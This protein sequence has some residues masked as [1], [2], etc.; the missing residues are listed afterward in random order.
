MLTKV[1]DVDIDVLKKELKK[2][3]QDS[4]KDQAEKE[5]TNWLF[6]E[7]MLRGKIKPQTKTLLSPNDYRYRFMNRL[8]SK[9]RWASVKKKMAKLLKIRRPTF[10]NIDNVTDALVMY[11]LELSL[12]NEEELVKFLEHLSALSIF[13]GSLPA[14]VL[15]TFCATMF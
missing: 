10:S 8:E 11:G 3:M 13:S 5:L 14:S 2:M 1:E 12:A 4:K 7:F 15:S 6:L 9:E